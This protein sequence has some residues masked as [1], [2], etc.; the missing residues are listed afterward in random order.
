[1][2]LKLNLPILA[3]AVLLLAGIATAYTTQIRAPAVLSNENSG[4][5]TNI[6]LNLTSGN[7]AVSITGPTTVGQDTLASAQTAAAYAAGYLG[8]NESAYNFTYN[9]KDGSSNVSG[10]SAGLAFTLLA[11]EAIKHESLYRNFTVTGTIDPSG[12]VGEVGGVFDKLGAAKADGARYALVPYALPTDP[13]YLTY[14]VTQ[15]TFNIPIVEVANVSQALPYVNASGAS[16]AKPL[17]VNFS[18]HYDL[19]GLG[20]ANLSC[21]GCNAS[22]FGQLVNFTFGMVRNATASIGGNFTSA[23][24][25]FSNSLGTFMNISSK[26]YMYE[27]ADL[28]FLQYSD[29][30]A[31]ANAGSFTKAAAQS[32]I[33]NVSSYCSSL[34]PPQLTG[35]NYE[36]VIGG[37][38]RQGWSSYNLAQ[39][40]HI[41]NASNT[42][43]D[44]IFSVQSLA[45][46]YAWCRSA[47]E[48]Y[49]I[50]SRMGGS[51]VGFGAQL[52]AKAL[53]AIGSIKSM[54]ADPLYVASAESAYNS[55]LYGAALYGATYAQSFASSPPSQ[56]ATRLS[57]LILA[58]VRNSTNGIWPSQFA[59]S[60]LFALEQANARGGDE[61]G[62]LTSAYITSLLA[63]NLAQTN[64]AITSSFVPVS[65]V[66]LSEISGLNGAIANQSAEIA[67]I[68]GQL[69]QVYGV[70]IA[71]VAVIA[72]MAI[73]LLVLFLNRN[74]RQ[75]APQNRNNRRRK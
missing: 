49:G 14:Y 60:A 75:P 54:P 50:A 38:V 46:S 26:G 55:S 16:K 34:A 25:S 44:V 33:D 17:A 66:S 41:L 31:L 61:T 42:T 8:V 52:K 40:Q 22:Y 19:N 23:K 10:P 65:N 47:S 74:P 36:Y 62:N 2:N 11:I 15:Q 70:L 58:N 59:D 69:T 67:S 29:I 24:A 4:I 7:G 30:Y 28:A 35:T 1:M 37:E 3:F 6:S 9:I 21:S 73:L 51:P 72:A 45:P 68:N 53:Q 39:V 64:N 48:M 18:I 71:M 57:A 5:L 13:E 12:N 43:D 20:P 63:A 56:N 32:L 27:G